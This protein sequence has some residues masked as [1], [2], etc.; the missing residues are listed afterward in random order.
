[1]YKV[2]VHTA[3]DDRHTGKA[4]EVGKEYELSAE[5][6]AEIKSVGK[7]FISVIGKVEEKPKKATKTKAKTK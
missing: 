5:R 4:Y 3:F 7:G 2:L 6:I 1:M